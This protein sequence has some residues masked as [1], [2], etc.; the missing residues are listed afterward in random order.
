M[1]LTPVKYRLKMLHLFS[2]HYLVAQVLIMLLLPLLL[3]NAGV[4][5]ITSVHLRHILHKIYFVHA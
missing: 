5:I 2:T 3:I 1:S 4:C